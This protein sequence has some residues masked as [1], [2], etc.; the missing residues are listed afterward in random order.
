MAQH[1]HVIDAFRP[2]GHPR[3]QAGHLHIGVHPGR[4]AG[5]DMTGG[6]VRQPAPLRQGHQR[7]QPARDTRFGSSND[8]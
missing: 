6:E 1:V 4:D 7:D 5:P 2:G 3:D 8:A